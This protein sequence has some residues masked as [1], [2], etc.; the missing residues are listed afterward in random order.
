NHLLTLIP[1][2][3]TLPDGRHVPFTLNQLGELAKEHYFPNN[4]E[5]YKYYDSDVRTQ[6]GAISSNSSYWLLMTR[7]VL[8]GTRKKAYTEQQEMVKQ[9]A[10]KGWGLPSG[11]EAATSILAHYAQSGNRQERLFGVSPWTYTRCTP[12]QLISDC[13]G[14]FDGDCPI[15]VGGFGPEGLSADG[16]D[17]GIDFHGVACC[18]KFY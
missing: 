4:A 18:R 16:D 10:V 17:Y 11:L 2:H 12:E 5:G 1:S 14:L 6:F 15:T 8:Q 9:Y 7:D 13:W 3:V